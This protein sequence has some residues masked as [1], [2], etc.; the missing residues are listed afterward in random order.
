MFKFLFTTPG[1]GSRRFRQLGARQSKSTLHTV[2]ANTLRLSISTTH[3][4]APYPDND[5]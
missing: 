4:I 1:R 2:R 5:T 3:S